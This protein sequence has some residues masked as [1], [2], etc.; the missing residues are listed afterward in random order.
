MDLRQERPYLNVDYMSVANMWAVVVQLHPISPTV[1]KTSQ[2]RSRRLLDRP[3]SRRARPKFQLPQ[4]PQQIVAATAAAHGR[5]QEL[6]S[7][8]HHKEA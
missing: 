1:H 6:I 8:G 7:F 2:D 5:A 3:P 4:R